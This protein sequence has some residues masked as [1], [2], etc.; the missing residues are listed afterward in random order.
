[1]GNP[2]IE[3][4]ARTAP[5]RSGGWTPSPWEGERE[6]PRTLVDARTAD[7]RKRNAPTVP[8]CLAAG[9]LVEALGF[10]GGLSRPKSYDG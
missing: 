8:L 9:G 3:L 6:T 2:V 7:A 5:I 4:G 10:G 1:M